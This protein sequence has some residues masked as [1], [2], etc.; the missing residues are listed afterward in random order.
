MANKYFRKNLIP[1]AAAEAVIYTVP[2]AN[3][4]VASSLRI[5]NAN[6]TSSILDVL[7]YPLGGATPYYLLRTYSLPVHATMDALSGVPLVLEA[8]DELAVESSEA[9]VT[10]Y[11]SYLEMD[12]N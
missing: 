8:S 7:V 4:A 9:D 1:D 3:T 5:T 2:A 10:F 11:L 6:S 12:R